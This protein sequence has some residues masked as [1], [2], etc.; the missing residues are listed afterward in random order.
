M[1]EEPSIPVVAIARDVIQE[2]PLAS[3]ITVSP[4]GGGLI[5][6]TFL[7]E[8]AG[9]RQ[10]LQRLHRI[11]GAE[12]NLD[13]DV[14]T[15]H[16]EARGV[17]T[18]RLVPTT[19]GALFVARPDGVW[20]LQTFISGHTFHRLERPAMAEAAGA[21][22]AR[23]HAA[24]AD[25]AH[26]FHFRR[27]FVHDTAHHRGLLEAAL[28]EETGHALHD[29]AARLAE[30]LFAAL[31]ALPRWETLALPTRIAHGDL[32]ISNLLFA[33]ERGE[34]ARCLVDLDTLAPMRLPFEL[35]D[36]WRSWCN[37]A[38]EDT[39][40]TRFDLE[41]LA[42]AWRG[43]GPGAAAFITQEEQGLLVAGVLTIAVELAIRF[44][45]D[46]LRERYFGWDATRFPSRGAHNLVRAQGQAAL[47]RSLAAQRAEA[48]RIV[49]G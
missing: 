46:A 29:A 8:S 15:R 42:A 26:S 4:L 32:K 20:R 49:S 40:A 10:V 7:V 21:L 25:L 14:V 35:G 36:A 18:P 17:L 2:W 31:D 16:L 33:D 41:L 23:F 3:P 44:C 34:E 37:P 47:A 5:N 6:E 30:E 9:G 38:G 13:I 11:F 1:P 48:E 27:A 45:A 39:V 24:L 43:Y 19:G 22:V 28:R 12:V